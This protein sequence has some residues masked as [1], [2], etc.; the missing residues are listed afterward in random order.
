MIAVRS[1]LFAAIPMLL[2]ADDPAVDYNAK[3][4]AFARSKIGEK[5]GD[6]DCSTLVQEAMRDAGAKVL[7]SP[8][9]D[10]EYLWGEPLK[11]LKDARPGDVL[12]FEKVKFSG[13]RRKLGDD[14]FPVLIFTRTSLPHHSAIV[15]AVGP[16][17]KTITMLH[18]NGPGPDG[19]SLKIV[20]ETTLILSEMQKGGSLKAYRPVAPD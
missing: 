8:A 14:G 5:V 2:A 12:Q 1:L 19:K 13:Q 18:Q 16:K 7:L 11:S 9:A 20:Q 15:T 10:G 6:G 17:G 4:A 3:V